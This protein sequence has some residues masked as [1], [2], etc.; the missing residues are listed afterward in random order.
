MFLHVQFT[1]VLNMWTVNT[2]LL[3]QFTFVLTMY[4]I[5]VP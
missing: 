2:L 3:V 5:N 1:S 4:T